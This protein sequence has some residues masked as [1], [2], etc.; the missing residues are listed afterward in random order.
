MTVRRWLLLCVMVGAA[1]PATPRE[2]V[3]VYTGDAGGSV[4]DCG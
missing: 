3:V 1:V 2:L 4:E